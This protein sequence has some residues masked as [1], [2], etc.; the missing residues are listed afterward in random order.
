MK[1]KKL[2]TLY[3]SGCL[4]FNLT[5]KAASAAQSSG[6]Q[7]INESDIVNAI[8][9]AG[10]LA[11]TITVNARLSK[12][13]VELATFQNPKATEKD[14]KIEAVLLAK[15]VM[16]LSPDQIFRVTV[17]FYGSNSLASYKSV[18]ITSGDV[19]AF[20]VGSIGQEQLLQS[21][22]LKEDRLT[23]PN[24]RVNSYVSEGQGRRNRQ[25][26][27][28][29]EG[30][31]LKITAAQDTDATP[32]EIVL[33]GLKLANKGFEAAPP[34][35]KT[36]ELALADLPTKTTKKMSFSR[37]KVKALLS[38]LEAD[39]ES[40][41]VASVQD[42]QVPTIESFSLAVYEVTEGSLKD[43]RSSLLKRLK[44]LLENG[45]NP[46][47]QVSLDFL[48][49]ETFAANG[50]S[51]KL[52]E[53]LDSLSTLVGKFEENLKNAKDYKPQ[54]S[55]KP[56]AAAAP[57]CHPGQDAKASTNAEDQASG[58]LKARLLQNPEAYM[59][60][61]ER[62]LAAATASKNAEDHS[63][64]P[65]V[66]EFAIS[67]L[68]AAGRAAEAQKYEARLQSIKHKQ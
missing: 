48:A 23:D 22:K 52:K 66:L 8:E 61:M 4:L 56:A 41:E 15:T 38:T 19:R 20:A 49:L 28:V 37:Q 43:E 35:V 58:E 25:I 30:D 6:N 2:L 18:T 1:I 59:A 10:I 32:L 34:E 29:I 17:Y 51:A 42:R 40:V 45:V 46:G 60:N 7:I 47:R 55:Q 64:F 67:T 57:A 13:E 53:G 62:K 63:N 68:K 27:S 65:T 16:D 3:A 33:E 54:S 12:E 26:K 11:P 14:C 24:K 44:R 31:I 5:I 50:Q 39:V 9:K 36:V 21:L